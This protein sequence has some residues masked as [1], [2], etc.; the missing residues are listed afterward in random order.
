MFQTSKTIKK[1][2]IFSTRRI[3]NSCLIT[4]QTKHELLGVAREDY[5]AL[6]Q[7][8]NLSPIY[9]MSR[10]ISSKVSEPKLTKTN[11]FR[12]YLGLKL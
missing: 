1:Y 11:I 4:K 5:K 7:V 6:Q 8:R 3:Y 12:L 9:G 10:E 2:L